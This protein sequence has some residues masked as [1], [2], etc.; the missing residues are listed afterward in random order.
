MDALFAVFCFT[1]SLHSMLVDGSFLKRSML[2]RITD[3]RDGCFC[4]L[5]PDAIIYN[6][7]LMKP[8]GLWLRRRNI[9]E[10]M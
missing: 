8:P 5:N 1:H 10:S 6:I 9:V 4:R 3:I 2:I 7:G